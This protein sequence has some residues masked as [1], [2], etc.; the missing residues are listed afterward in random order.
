MLKWSRTLLEENHHNNEI[1][2]QAPKLQTLETS[3][4]EEV[5]TDLPTQQ[6]LMKKLLEKENERYTYQTQHEDNKKLKL[7]LEESQQYAKQLQRVIHYLRERSEES[8]LE[9]KQLKEDI[10]S[11]HEAIST[12][13][14]ECA[15]AKAEINRLKQQ[16]A[17]EQEKRQEACEE[18]QS[19]Q[20]QFKNLKNAVFNSKKDLLSS[21]Q[22]AEDL[23]IQNAKYDKALQE[24]DRGLE[25]L[26][27]EIATIKH[28]LVRGLREMQALESR[29][30]DA[31]QNKV[32]L[33]NKLHLT[34]QQAEKQKEEFYTLHSQQEH[35]IEQLNADLSALHQDKQKLEEAL[36][37]I[38]SSYEEREQ[39]IKTAQQHLA[40][41][42]KEVSV[43]SEK[44]EEQRTLIAELQLSLAD[45]QSRL[46]ST[47]NTLELQLQHEK[48]LH[49]QTHENLKTAETQVKKW[50]DKYFQLQDKYQDL[51]KQN[52]EL[53]IL[54]EKQNQAQALLNSLG[55]VMG[56]TSGHPSPTL[57]LQNSTT[58]KLPMENTGNRSS[59]Q[60]KPEN[61]SQDTPASQAPDDKHSLFEMP[62]PFVRY[63]QTLFD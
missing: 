53:K 30:Q 15:T 49:E 6:L 1:A 2:I 62:E 47:Q 60:L 13:S 45:C 17:E 33:A 29:C 25:A 48:R 59:L 42:L 50:E 16:L 51:E 9:A 23:R 5:N 38:K 20:L 3:P 41:K 26:E 34:Q 61:T 39:S 31:V 28:S 4:T 58:S 56:V 19:L 7:D 10:Q 63:K 44:N 24:R 57:A 37:N 52:R 35:K 12:L 21:N 22:L 27:H 18:V 8:H 40:K 11:S 36:N 46:N 55:M 32:S 14:D 54:E 43:L